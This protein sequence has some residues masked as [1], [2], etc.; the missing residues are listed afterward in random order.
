M[1]AVHMGTD[2]FQQYKFAANLNMK[3]I[4]FFHHEHINSF[5]CQQNLVVM[6]CDYFVIF[7]IKMQQSNEQFVCQQNLVVMQCDYFEKPGLDN[8]KTRTSNRKYRIR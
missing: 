2:K 5:V 7:V 8:R 1:L 3:G 4:S 6:Q